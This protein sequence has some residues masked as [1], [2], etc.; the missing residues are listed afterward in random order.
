[1]T[2]GCDGERGSPALTLIR[3]CGDYALL[4]TLVAWSSGS[5][6]ITIVDPEG[7]SRVFSPDLS[8]LGEADRRELTRLAIDSQ[9]TRPWWT[10]PIADALP[11][12]W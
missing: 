9:R 7:G 3:T 10:A 11:L 2:E 1:M 4:P 5:S 12:Y 8:P 6:D